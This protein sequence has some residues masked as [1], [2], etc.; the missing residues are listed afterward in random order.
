MATGDLAGN[1]DE[2]EMGAYLL[3]VAQIGTLGER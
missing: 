1:T 3:A 2:S